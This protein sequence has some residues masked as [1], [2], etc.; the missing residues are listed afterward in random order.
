MRATGPS[1]FTRLMHQRAR[2]RE[3]A[4]AP[5]TAHHLHCVSRRNGIWF[6]RRRRWTRG[7]R[8]AVPTTKISLQ[9]TLLTALRALLVPAVTIAMLIASTSFLD[10]RFTRE[11]VA[12]AIIAALL[13]WIFMTKDD[14]QRT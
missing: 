5:S 8:N 10:V 6:V 3:C 1:L 2:T 7:E 12:L 4:R 9:V 13:T 11:Y 14:S